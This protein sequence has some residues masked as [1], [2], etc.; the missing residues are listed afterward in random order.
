MSRAAF[1]LAALLPSAVHGRRCSNG[2]CLHQT[3]CNDCDN[4]KDWKFEE[5]LDRAHPL[6]CP[7]T[8]VA[9]SGGCRKTTDTYPYNWNV[10]CP[11]VWKCPDGYHGLRDTTVQPYSGP[12]CSIFW[13]CYADTVYK[14]EDNK[15]AQ[16]PG[17]SAPPPEA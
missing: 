9:G 12:G 13:K 1:A 11:D 10:I 2:K 16:P 3:T 6:K 8:T 4:T 5:D 17:G 14:F 15:E 7:M